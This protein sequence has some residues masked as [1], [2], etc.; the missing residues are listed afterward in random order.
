MLF[1][2]QRFVFKFWRQAILREQGVV[3][4][5]AKSVHQLRHDYG[6]SIT[7]SFVSLGRG[8]L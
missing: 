1:F 5:L 7:E 8:S 2:L 4:M 6:E 3:E